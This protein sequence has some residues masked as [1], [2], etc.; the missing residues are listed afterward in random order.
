MRSQ[1]DLVMLW[2]AEREMYP[3]VVKFWII[4]KKVKLA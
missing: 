1:S 3:E 4:K 2:A